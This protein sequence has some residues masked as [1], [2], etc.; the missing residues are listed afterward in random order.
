MGAE[1]CGTDFQGER[2]CNELHRGVKLLEHVM[3]IEGI[4]L[5]MRKKGIPELMVS[6]VMSLYDGEKTRVRVG[7]EL[8]EEFDVCTRDL[9]IHA[10]NF[11]CQLN[12]RELIKCANHVIIKKQD[13]MTIKIMIRTRGL[14]VILP[15]FILLHFLGCF[16]THL[17]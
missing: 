10:L 16:V 8:S 5:G 2:G 4:G 15:Q 12:S 1:C 3:K 17:L 6:E 9:G 7:L 14:L 13:K 11:Y